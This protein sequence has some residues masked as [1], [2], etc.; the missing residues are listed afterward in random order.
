[1]I[2]ISRLVLWCDGKARTRPTVSAERRRE[3]AMICNF[4]ECATSGFI[5]PENVVLLLRCHTS[6]SRRFRSQA[7]AYA[8]GTRTAIAYRNDLA[9]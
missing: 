7:A 6:V 3:N 2:R 8:E 1:M 9:K 4:T 5:K